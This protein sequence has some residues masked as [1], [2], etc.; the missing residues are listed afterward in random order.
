MPF[1]VDAFFLDAATLN[2]HAL[3][4]FLTQESKTIQQLGQIASS[5][6]GD[7]LQQ[8]QDSIDELSGVAAAK[9]VTKPGATATSPVSG[10]V[11][12]TTAPKGL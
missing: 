1:N 10:A 11:D 8:L 9:M 5:L 7:D 4:D 6:I 2:P 3:S 12:K